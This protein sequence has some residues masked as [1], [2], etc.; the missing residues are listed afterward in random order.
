MASHSAA[1]WGRCPS[2]PRTLAIMRLLRPRPR[3]RAK[4]K[5]R[6]MDRKLLSL[7][8]DPEQYS[9]LLWPPA[10]CN[11]SCI[12][13]ELAYYSY[14]M[15]EW[16]YT[17]QKAAKTDCAIWPRLKETSFQPINASGHHPSGCGAASGTYGRYRAERARRN[18]YSIHFGST[19]T[20]KAI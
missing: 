6:S 12:R 20:A 13:Q 4:A 15:Q 17:W 3:L 18:I 9:T 7:R 19:P 16:P 1:V 8:C 10:M 11:H 5:D 14:L 2:T